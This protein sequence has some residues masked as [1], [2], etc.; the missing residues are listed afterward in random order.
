MSAQAKA[1][2]RGSVIPLDAAIGPAPYG[3]S[4]AQGPNPLYYLPRHGGAGASIMS[5]PVLTTNP[6]E[7]GSYEINFVARVGGIRATR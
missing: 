3:A 5:N 6:A 2:S 7:F 1:P 4:N